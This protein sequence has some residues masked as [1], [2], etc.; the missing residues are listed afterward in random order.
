VTISAINSE[1]QLT[2]SIDGIN[3]AEFVLNG[4]LLTH[5]GVLKTITV[6]GQFE[7][8]I[9]TSLLGGRI[10]LFACCTF[11]D[12]CYLALC[13]LHS[14]CLWL[15]VV[16]NGWIYPETKKGTIF[17]KRKLKQFKDI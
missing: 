8:E 3:W 5:E 7:P 4:A 10:G 6:C 9:A 15:A 14:M 11:D 12:L 2:E 16:S 1:S 17:R 13:A